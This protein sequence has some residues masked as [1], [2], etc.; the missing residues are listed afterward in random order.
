MHTNVESVYV[1]VCA[2]SMAY[3][4]THTCPEISAEN[5]S[6]NSRHQ[7]QPSFS[8]SQSSTAPLVELPASYG[9]RPLTEEEIDSINVRIC[10]CVYRKKLQPV[11]VCY[12]ESE[13][14]PLLMCTHKRACILSMLIITTICIAI[15]PDI[16]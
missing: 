11:W 1:C 12:S 8:N 13:S 6:H 16:Y 2:Y 3:T 9:R 14:L 15:I 10:R 4:Y 5:I 7:A